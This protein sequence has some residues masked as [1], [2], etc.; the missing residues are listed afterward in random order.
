MSK[1]V[2]IPVAG[3]DAK[4]E[5]GG[6]LTEGLPRGEA[7][8]VGRHAPAH[9][10]I[11]KASA[12]DSTAD[13]KEAP[14][15]AR[16]SSPEQDNGEAERLQ[17]LNRMLAVMAKEEQRQTAALEARLGEVSETPPRRSARCS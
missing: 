10:D 13:G 9:G 16:D 4:T 14:A 7:P 6:D 2:G 12:G 1:G 17:R 8:E 3:G 15:V 5:A 11:R